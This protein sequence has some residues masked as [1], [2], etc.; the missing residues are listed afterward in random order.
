M[1]TVILIWFLLIPGSIVYSQSYYK[2]NNS[3]TFESAAVLCSKPANGVKA[4]DCTGEWASMDGLHLIL[5]S[6][7]KAIW[8]DDSHIYYLT[9]CSEYDS[10]EDNIKI[11]LLG[12]DYCKHKSFCLRETDSGIEIIE[13][14]NNVHRHIFK[15]LIATQQ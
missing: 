6:N 15:E 12:N 5:Y 11:S 2:E 8:R 4:T 7:N 1:K 10:Q 3:A 9:W 14:Q 13:D